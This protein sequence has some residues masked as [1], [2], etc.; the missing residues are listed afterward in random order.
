MGDPV[1]ERIG[2]HMERGNELFRRSNQLHEDT[3]RFTRELTRR[4]EMVI[5]E[6]VREVTAGR[7]VLEDLHE[8]SQAQREA[9]LALIDELRSESLGR[10]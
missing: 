3:R 7:R 6:L 2:R 4:N 1:L 8:E 5:H 10:S 9:L